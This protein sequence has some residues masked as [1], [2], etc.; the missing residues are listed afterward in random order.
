MSAAGEHPVLAGPPIGWRELPRRI[1]RRVPIDQLFREQAGAGAPVGG[2]AVV[3]LR[4]ASGYLGAFVRASS[5]VSG[6]PAPPAAW[7]LRPPR[8]RRGGW[9]SPGSRFAVGSWVLGSIG[10]GIHVQWFGR[11]DAT[12]GAAAG[13]GVLPV[14]LWLSNL[15]LLAGPVVD[16]E[17]GRRPDHARGSPRPTP[18]GDDA[19]P[20]GSVR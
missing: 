1:V 2:S 15:A 10:F 11:H 20:L 14:W 4:S 7:K 18:A 12:Y 16:D 9:F 19:R 6:L 5:R 17:L 3:G 13:A 8:P